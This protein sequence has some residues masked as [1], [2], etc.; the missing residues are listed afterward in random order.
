MA[1][2][3]VDRNGGSI[4]F[5]SP[6]RQPADRIRQGVLAPGKHPEVGAWAGA[7]ETWDGLPV[8]RRGTP[9]MGRP[10]KL[11]E[12]TARA[13]IDALKVGCPVRVACQAA[14]VGSTTFKTWMVR[15]TS[16]DESD[17]P[18]RAFRADV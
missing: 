1:S 6:P 4:E 16:G 11:G 10:T 17:A 7:Q 2:G 8:E 15:G 9:P 3:P 5:L 18:F 13:I 12:A 14:G